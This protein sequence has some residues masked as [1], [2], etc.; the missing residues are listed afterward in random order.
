MLR[1]FWK[2]RSGSVAIEMAK[3]AAAI[4]FLSVISA[5][6]LSSTLSTTEAER[7]QLGQLAQTAG[8]DSL[9]LDPAVTGSLTKRAGQV[10]LDP[11]VAGR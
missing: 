2:G 10:R 4:A 8:R 1:P 5:N 7:T 3:A 9:D 6:W 11:C